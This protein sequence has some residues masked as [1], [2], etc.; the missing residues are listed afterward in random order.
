MDVGIASPDVLCVEEGQW[1][2]SPANAVSPMGAWAQWD[3]KWYGPDDLHPEG[4]TIVSDLL[5]GIA[6]D[7]WVLKQGQTLELDVL[8]VADEVTVTT[9]RMN[10]LL[11]QQQDL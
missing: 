4:F 6:F 2:V 3:R 1:V 8:I 7:T 9:E 10:A 5:I 11:S